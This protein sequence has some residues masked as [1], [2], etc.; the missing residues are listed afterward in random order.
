[1][2][3]RQCVPLVSIS[4]SMI[5]IP[6][7]SSIFTPIARAQR[8]CFVRP[9]SYFAT[10][11]DGKVVFVKGP[12]LIDDEGEGQFCVPLGIAQ[13]K[14]KCCPQL[15]S[16]KYKAHFLI[17][18][19]FPDTPI[20]TRRQW[21]D[22]GNRDPCVFI[23]F[24]NLL[25]DVDLPLKKFPA[26]G[27]WQEF[28]GIDWESLREQNVIQ[29]LDSFS[30]PTIR[31]AGMD[32]AA[33]YILF[34]WIMGCSD[35]A[36]RNHIWLP[37]KQLFY[38][39]DEEV[40]G[41]NIS[42]GTAVQS[43][44]IKDNTKIIVFLTQHFK[45]NWSSIQPV[46]QQWLTLFKTMKVNAKRFGSKVAAAWALILERLANIAGP[47]GQSIILE[48]CLA[49]KKSTKR[50]VVSS[51]E[52]S[53]V[54]KAK[55]AEFV[56]SPKT[57][58]MMCPNRRK[59]VTQHGHRPDACKSAFQK[60]IR[61]STDAPLENNEMLQ[62]ALGAFFDVFNLASFF[63][64]NS[65]AKNL[66][67]NI[68]NRLAICAAE[69]CG[70][71]NVGLVVSIINHIRQCTDRNLKKRITPRPDMLVGFITA[72]ARS[73]KSRLGSE[74]WA[75]YGVL[76]ESYSL[77]SA[78]AAPQE[79]DSFY[80]DLSEAFQAPSPKLAYRILKAV[81]DCD[82]DEKSIWV[83]RVWAVLK[84][85][86][87][88]WVF[89]CLHAS[90]S[91]FCEEAP[92]IRLA[93]SIALYPECLGKDQAKLRGPMHCKALD[94]RK[95]TDGDYYLDEVFPDY[96]YDLHTAKGRQLDAEMKRQGE[97]LRGPLK[98]ALYGAKLAFRCSIRDRVAEKL[99]IQSKTECK[100]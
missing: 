41:A 48:S 46:L 25:G 26:K 47:D 4:P 96:V 50:K 95:W 11:S 91:H 12:Y 82:E 89:D 22:K 52:S 49:V 32:Q 27:K 59:E 65:N 15:N 66:R 80:D 18:D 21:I 36:S 77:P 78:S 16:I 93:F 1:M 99:Y 34:R 79:L 10:N 14:K 42:L 40:I 2:I 73:P 54:K 67:T 56:L 39:V 57:G 92:S 6:L 62:M 68:L 44:S 69:D 100:K 60:G 13:I 58:I 98:F 9:C 19:L 63:P 94:S 43:G 51:N 45:N 7:E 33:L 71:G 74:Q 28:T 85:V 61:R 53:M 35:L 64:T 31:A 86:L 55:L 3:N 72:L 29:H 17:P 84:K 88:E 81:L 83:R 87:P 90:F 20:G 75:A 97:D 23:E 70:I 5:S 24:E 37:A 76:G 30:D 8:V 38:G